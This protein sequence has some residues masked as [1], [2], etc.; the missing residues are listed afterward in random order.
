VCAPALGESDGLGAV[1]LAVAAGRIATERI[2]EA[3]VLGLAKGRGC[4]IVLGR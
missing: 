2:D 3:L 4:A 1:A